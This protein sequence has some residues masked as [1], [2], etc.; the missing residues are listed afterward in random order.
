MK[1]LIV[2]D[3][4]MARLILRQVLQRNFGA[5]VTEVPNGLEAL[6]AVEAE[7][8]D[9]I[10]LDLRM[11]VMDGLTVLQTIRATPKHARTPVVILTADRK[12]ENVYRSINLGVSDY[13]TKPFRGKEIAER[14]GQVMGQAV[15]GVGRS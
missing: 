13:L 8:F 4:A 15:A 10:I 14:L 12:E 9:L 2:D 7:D 1:V 6:V 3:D 5:V 11:P